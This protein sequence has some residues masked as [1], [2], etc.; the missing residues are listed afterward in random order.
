MG[1]I[2]LLLFLASGCLMTIEL[3]AGRVVAPYVGVSLYTWT[4]IIGACLTGMSF[5]HLAGGWLADRGDARRWLPRMFIA[6]AV[7]TSALFLA[8]PV[9][10]TM[11][12]ALS[13]RQVP[14]LVGIFL[15][16]TL[17]FG[18]PCFFLAAISPLLYKAALQSRQRVGSTV[19]RLAASGI[20]GS[21]AGTYATGFWLIPAYGTR[22]ILLGITLLLVAL[23]AYSLVASPVRRAITAAILIAL[24]LA[25]SAALPMRAAAQCDV[26]SAYYCIRTVVTAGTTES[27]P[28]K[29]L[30]LDYLTHAGYAVNDPDALWYPYEQVVAWI[31]KASAEPDVR[32]LFLGGGGY[33]LPH[34][35]EKNFPWATID[36]V[37]VDPAV[38]Q[39]A[40]REFVPTAKRIH[41]KNGDAR[42]AMTQLRPGRKYDVVFADVFSDL[43]VP[44]HLTT[45]EFAQ[46]VK[47]R[48]AQPG[49]YI[50][51]VIDNRDGGPLVGAMTATLKKVFPYVDVL[52][53]NGGGI[54][55]GPHI[56]VASANPLPWAEWD[57]HPERPSFITGR[58]KVPDGGMV[59]TDDYVPT[60]NLLLPIFSDR[61]GVTRG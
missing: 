25:A 59:L 13:A 53:G 24:P 50:V 11:A 41:S 15:L 3:V 2:Y 46:L 16:S 60:D 61:W 51:N 7:L 33:M 6:A 48:L 27:G 31:M 38:T 17:F 14:A 28:V 22:S 1:S 26:E 12:E 29:R 37:E 18:L 10:G 4:G 32:T 54:V 35:V 9:I 47:S 19:G 8:R 45:V 42:L 20:A 57:Q 30:R 49:L 5:G 23:G 21:I 44:Y 56:L 52:P 40:M 34:W 36:V 39:V 58:M 55:R 43:A